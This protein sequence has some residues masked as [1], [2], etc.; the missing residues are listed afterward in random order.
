ME[1]RQRDSIMAG[2]TI[3]A[4]QDVASAFGGFFTAVGFRVRKLGVTLNPTTSATDSTNAVVLDE[5]TH[6]FTPKRAENKYQALFQGN[7][8]NIE[9]KADDGTVSAGIFIDGVL[10][11]STVATAYLGEPPYSQ[12]LQCLWE[13]V[14]GLTV[15]PHTI[16]V[17]VWG[18]EGDEIEA[19]EDQRQLVVREIEGV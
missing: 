13:D 9:K 16:E 8:Q 17:K 18:S 14:D 12:S 5:M 19:I 4:V 11:E 15:A 3:K 2:R 10:D 7:F 6:T 1:G